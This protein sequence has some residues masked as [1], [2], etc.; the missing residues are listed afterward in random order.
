MISIVAIILVSAMPSISSMTQRSQTTASLNRLVGAINYTRH[1]AVQYGVTATLCRIK[2]NGKCGGDW[3]QDL[4]VFTDH[5]RNAWLEEEDTVISVV[6]AQDSSTTVKWRSFQN[7]QYLQ[8]TAL[9]YTNFQNGNFVI[10]P[11]SGDST[12]ARQLVV[13]VQ[14]RVRINHSV[15]EAGHP[16]DR[17]GKRLRC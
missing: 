14:G 4:V 10:C 12:K 17:K 1:T 16:I 8:M 5:N 9:G 15:N 11:E 2:T 7:R 6:A 3:S 13:N